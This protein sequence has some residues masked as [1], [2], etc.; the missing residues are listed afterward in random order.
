MIHN[1]MLFDQNLL[2]VYR[3]II[4][5]TLKTKINKTNTIPRMCIAL[6]F[7]VT[8]ITSVILV[9]LLLLLIISNTFA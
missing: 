3:N 9:V 8:R 6:V 4:K 2:N 7:L 1:V 5:H